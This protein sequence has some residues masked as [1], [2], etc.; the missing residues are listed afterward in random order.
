MGACNLR[1]IILA[2]IT[3]QDVILFCCMSRG[4]NLRYPIGL[5]QEYAY[6]LASFIE[7]GCTHFTKAS[8]P[9]FSILESIPHP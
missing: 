4:I 8:N 9:L 5:S 2:I 6:G 3:H 1:E 7:S